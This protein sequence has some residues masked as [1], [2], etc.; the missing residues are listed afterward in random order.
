[1]LIKCVDGVMVQMSDQEEAD[2]R[3][4]WAANAAKVAPPPPTPVD[5][6]INDPKAL[7]ALK[8]ALAKANGAP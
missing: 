8:A 2:I 5:D 4:E 7:S 6:I 1:M 3:A